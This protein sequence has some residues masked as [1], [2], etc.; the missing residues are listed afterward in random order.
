MDPGRLNDNEQLARVNIALFAGCRATRQQK[1]PCTHDHSLPRKNGRGQRE[2]A[3]VITERGRCAAPF[4]SRPPLYREL[5]ALPTYQDGA[6][7]ETNGEP[8]EAEHQGQWTHSGQVRP[9]RR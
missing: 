4:G 3:A 2:S 8:N 6:V 1:L 5:G 9:A 7:H